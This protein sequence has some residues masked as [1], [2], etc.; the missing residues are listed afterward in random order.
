ML[1]AFS[2]CMFSPPSCLIYCSLHQIEDPR[3]VSR[4]CSCPGE[5]RARRYW[6][7]RWWQREGSGVD[8]V[9]G[10]SLRARVFSNELLNKSIIHFSN[11][12]YSTR[13]GPGFQADDPIRMCFPKVRNIPN[14]KP[15][16]PPVKVLSRAGLPR[17]SNGE[18]VISEEAGV[19]V[20]SPAGG[21]TG[22][23][24]TSQQRDSSL[25]PLFIIN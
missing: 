23:F 13:G 4:G 3:H 5:D 10:P 6:R 14:L 25:P 12:L 19:G 7:S 1:S 16:Q 8:Q 9:N 2:S 21:G 18:G 20:G 15:T 24:K 22:P 11:P 17:I